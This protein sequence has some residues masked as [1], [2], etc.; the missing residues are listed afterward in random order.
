MMFRRRHKHE[1]PSPI[2]IAQR[3]AAGAAAV[4][5]A[6]TMI[7]TTT[8]PTPVD[9]A[10]RLAD[11]MHFAQWSGWTWADVIAQALTLFRS[12]ERDVSPKPKH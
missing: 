10:R 3:A 8:I 5:R 4:R 6:R 2:V 1:P 7:G 12:E 9:L 11:L